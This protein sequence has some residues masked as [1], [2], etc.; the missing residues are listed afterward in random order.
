MR[1]IATRVAV[2]PS[3]AIAFW[4]IVG[5]VPWPGLAALAEASPTVLG[6]AL[7]AREADADEVAA[8]VRKVVVAVAARLG[9]ER[10]TERVP[11]HIAELVDRAQALYGTADLDAAARAYDGAIAEGLR[12]IDHLADP[13]A[14]IGAHVA[15][16]AIAL[17]RSEVGRAAEL[18]DRVARYDPRAPLV[19]DERRPR[20]QALLETAK[21]HAGTRPALTAEDLGDACHLADV[22]IVARSVGAPGA[23]S[24]PGAIEYLRFDARDRTCQPVLSAT[25]S[26]DDAVAISTLASLPLPDAVGA[27]PPLSPR[28][29]SRG[30]L[31]RVALGIGV[32]AL[33]LGAAGAGMAGWAHVRY[34]QLNADCGQTGDCSPANIEVPRDTS[35]AGYALVGVAAAAAVTSLIVWLVERRHRDHGGRESPRVP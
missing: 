28:R 22:V 5:V 20:M 8:R 25:A 11:L 27:P 30:R 26:A 1:R 15:R 24:A 29:A 18:M 21:H 34:Q 35:R 19:G 31:A 12:G 33:A 4:V 6:F 17:A 14:F 32:S 23:S 9:A 3:L 10:C 2:A 7:P 13:R 16:A